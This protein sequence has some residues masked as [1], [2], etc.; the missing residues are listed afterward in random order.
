MPYFMV[1]RFIDI[2]KDFP[3]TPTA[4]VEKYKIRAAGIGDATW[5][6][7]KHGWKVTRH[8]L[9]AP[10]GTLLLRFEVPAD[11]PPQSAASLAG[12]SAQRTASA[13]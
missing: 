4:K 11:E 2:V 7:E 10:D 8:G 5:D 9:S 6:R 1:P 3:R 13:A 12:H